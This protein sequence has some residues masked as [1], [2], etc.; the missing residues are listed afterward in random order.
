MKTIFRTS[1][2]EKEFNKNASHKGLFILGFAGV[3]VLAVVSVFS[4][5]SLYGTSLGESLYAEYAHLDTVL[6]FF[7]YL[8]VS[9]FIAVMV[10]CCKQVFS[11]QK[12][13]FSL[14]CG[15]GLSFMMEV[16]QIFVPGRSFEISDVMANFGGA[17]VGILIVTA[18]YKAIKTRKYI[19]EII[20]ERK[21]ELA[22]KR[23]AFQ[24]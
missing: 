20:A 2:T 1:N 12:M 5:F 9:I 3:A 13:Q 19:N 23:Y 4:C 14:I 18:I 10:C 15:G 21:R 17:I 8:V 7:F 11:E 16:L 6:H 24:G 22:E